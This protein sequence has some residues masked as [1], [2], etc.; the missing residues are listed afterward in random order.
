MTVVA[1]RRASAAERAAAIAAVQSAAAMCRDVQAGLTGQTGRA[2]GVLVKD[3][4]SPVTVA[5]FAAQALVCAALVEAL[6]AVTIV[7]EED[8]TDLGGAENRSLVATVAEL[9]G[10]Q[11]AADVTPATVLEWIGAGAA[12]RRQPVLDPRPDRRHEGLPARRAVRHRAGADRS[13]RGGPR[14]ARLSQPADA[15]RRAGNGAGGRRLGVWRDRRWRWRWLPIAVAEP[16]TLADSRVLRVGRVGPLR[17]RRLGARRRT[18]GH[19]GRA[20]AHRQPV[21]VR[22]GRARRRLGVPPSAHP[23]RLSREDLGPRRGRARGRRT[24]AGGS[25]MSSAHRSTSRRVGGSRPT[26]AS[27]PPTDAST[28]RSWT[29]SPA[30][31]TAGEFPAGS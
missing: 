21:Q 8:P 30:W 9:V 24:P 16:A 18:A 12:A 31:W 4:A 6:G 15:R 10:R 29:S 5:D 22:R 3:D 2:G 25:P 19:H 26:A 11:R 13:R 20:P 1:P 17:P 7:G 14:C 28:T 23:A 27:S